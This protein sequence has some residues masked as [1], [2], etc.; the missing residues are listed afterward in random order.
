MWLRLPKH[1]SSSKVF[2]SRSRSNKVINC[3][4]SCLF[5]HIISRSYGSFRLILIPASQMSWTPS[6]CSA[7]TLE[8]SEFPPSNRAFPLSHKCC[9]ISS[10]SLVTSKLIIFFFFFFF[11]WKPYWH[12][13]QRVC[14]QSI[15]ITSS[16]IKYSKCN[17]HFC[18]IN[19]ITLP[20]N[21][22]QIQIAPNPSV[23]LYVSGLCTCVC[24]CVIV[25]EASTAVSR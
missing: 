15:L 25:V 6:S 11:F 1:Q 2:W 8:P 21:Q 14:M 10:S 20:S 9:S 19:L 18:Q 22:I 12:D 24:A 3:F 7:I 5:T 17:Q 23:C 16:T 13:G 4:R